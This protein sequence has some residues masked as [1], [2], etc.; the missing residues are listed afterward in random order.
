MADR[1]SKYPENADGPFYVDEQCIACGV[2]PAE[3]PN[4]FEMTDDES[5]A[6]VRKQPE[7]DSEKNECE[8]AMASCPVD[9]IGNDGEEV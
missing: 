8:E 3:A 5:H 1:E 2:C 9:A 7:N 6:Y 4:N